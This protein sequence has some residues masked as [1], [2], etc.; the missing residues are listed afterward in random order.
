[1][2]YIGS[3]GVGN[4]TVDPRL[5]FSELSSAGPDAAAWLYGTAH[6]I[7][8]GG[9]LSILVA[10][11]PPQTLAKI[12][13]LLVNCFADGAE[14]GRATALQSLL[15]LQDPALAAYAD[16]PFLSISPTASTRELQRDLPVALK[17]WRDRPGIVLTRDR[18]EHV[19]K[20][21][22]VWDRREGWHE[23]QYESSAE[24]TFRQIGGDLK[25]S[26]STVNNR[27]R[28]A[29][30]LIT[31]HPYSPALWFKIFGPMKFSR[32]FGDEVGPISL[33]R[34]QRS[35]VPHP[36]A[37]AV[38]SATVHGPSIVEFRAHT[39]DDQR[40]CDLRLDV[41]ELRAQGKSYSEI[42][43]ELGASV[44]LAADLQTVC[45]RLEEAAPSKKTREH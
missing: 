42:C 8:L 32:L 11:L 45:E 7:T 37:D 23:G 33:R 36:V 5:S 24:R 34:P 9:Q 15:N 31:G 4:S 41:A 38:V 12:G 21:L 6:P 40:L 29:F 14:G 18:S 26:L 13:R 10:A 17:P 35:P 1:M 2:I 30:E 27:Y 39:F 44:D 20:Y 25:L 22:Q 43:R 19:I 16:V 28:S 3:L